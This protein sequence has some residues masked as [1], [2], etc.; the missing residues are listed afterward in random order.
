V[1]ANQPPSFAVALTDQFGYEGIKWTYQL[2]VI[3]D[4]EK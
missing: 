3:N 2:P 1:N 4:P